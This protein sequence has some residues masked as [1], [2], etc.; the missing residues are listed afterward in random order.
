MCMWWLFIVYKKELIMVF[1]F[2]TIEFGG[3]QR[4][5]NQVVLYQ[6]IFMNN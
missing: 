4:L 5:G 1:I 2:Q 3:N 6:T